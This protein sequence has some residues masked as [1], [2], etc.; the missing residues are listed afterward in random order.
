MF[1]LANFTH[2]TDQQQKDEE[3]RRHGDFC[4]MVQAETIENAMAR[5]REKMI[6]FRTSGSFFI[7]KCSIFI[8]EL[9]EFTQFPQD[10]AVMLNFKSFVGDPVMPFIACVV[11]D[12]QSDAC[13]IH[14]WRGKVPVTEGRKDSL[15]LEFNEP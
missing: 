13:S 5:F 6:D 9:I 8:S 10:D 7:G 14:D 3:E 2:V 4:M 15:F 1:F 12:E 11:P